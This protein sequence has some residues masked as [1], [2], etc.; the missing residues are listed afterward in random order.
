VLPRRVKQFLRKCNRAP[1]GGRKSRERERLFSSNA[2]CVS[3]NAKNP[4]CRRNHQHREQRRGNH[5]T[6][7]RRGDAPHN[8][9]PRAAAPHNGEETCDYHRNRHCNG[10][11]SQC[12]TLDDRLNEILFIVE[13]MLRCTRSNGLVQ[14]DGPV[15]SRVG[16]SFVRRTGH[17][18]S[19]RIHDAFALADLGVALFLRRRVAAVAALSSRRETS[20][21]ANL[22]RICRIHDDG[23]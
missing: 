3:L 2:D 14:I 17:G 15:L 11:H 5:A 22:P 8:F 7:H 12:G 9:R 23:K 4:V 19:S 6:D 1:N 13:P 21:D 16:C 10:P 20:P 18:G